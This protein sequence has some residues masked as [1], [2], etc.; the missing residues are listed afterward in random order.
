MIVLDASAIVELLAGT[1][2]GR[3][4]ADRIADPN[5]ALHVPHLADIEV[6]QVFR[7]YVQF[8]ELTAT[9]GAAQILALPVGARCE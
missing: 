2:T 4:V 8:G 3:L 6:A 7:R 9:D 1:I 5:E